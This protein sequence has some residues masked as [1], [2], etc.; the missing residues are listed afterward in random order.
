MRKR[1]RVSTQGGENGLYQGKKIGKENGK[2]GEGDK[3]VGQSGYTF[4]KKKGKND[5]GE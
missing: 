5:E 4:G 1:G 3:G 2:V